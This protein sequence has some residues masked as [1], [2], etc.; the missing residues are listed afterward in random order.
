M[1]TL[2]PREVLVGQ[3]AVSGDLWKEWAC[4]HSRREFCLLA[5]WHWVLERGFE[6]KWLKKKKAS[7][8]NWK[9]KWGWGEG[10]GGLKIRQQC[11]Q[12]SLDNRRAGRIK[13]RSGRTAGTPEGREGPCKTLA[14]ECEPREVKFLCWNETLCGLIS[15]LSVPSEVV[16]PPL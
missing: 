13:R 16:D 12:L 11:T 10:E 5:Q 4:P 9:G 15:D 6:E 2:C 3:A 7:E 8:K 1:E 14:T